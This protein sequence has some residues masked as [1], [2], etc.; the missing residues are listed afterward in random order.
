[1]IQKA[2]NYSELLAFLSEFRIELLSVLRITHDVLTYSELLSIFRIT[3][4]IHLSRGRAERRAR[5]VSH[6]D[7][8]WG[9][10]S[11]YHA[12]ILVSSSP[13]FFLVGIRTFDSGRVTSL[14]RYLVTGPYTGFNDGR[15][16]RPNFRRR[17]GPRPTN[18]KIPQNHK[19][20]PLCANRDLRFRE[21]VMAPLPP[22]YTGLP[23]Y[24]GMLPRYLVSSLFSIII[25]RK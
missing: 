12:L 2:Q 11:A 8:P 7:R 9:V 25:C 21:G 14:P 24:F 3:Q 22:L 17:G 18:L 4:R 1:M 13:R 10:L 20:P 15:G 23:R 5:N 16:P 6:L 19:G